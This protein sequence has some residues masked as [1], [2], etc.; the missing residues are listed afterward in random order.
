MS[1]TII[2]SHNKKKQLIIITPHMSSSSSV[3]F[4]NM[5]AGKGKVGAKQQ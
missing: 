5:L 4:L 2:T 1:F 3:P